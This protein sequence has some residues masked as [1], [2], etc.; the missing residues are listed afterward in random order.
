MGDVIA[1]WEYRFEPVDIYDLKRASATLNE[2]GKSGW[3]IVEL[4]HAGNHDGSSTFALLK[5][6][7]GQ[8]V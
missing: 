8:A 5:K 1:G 3:D 4:F 6:P 2:L 7:K